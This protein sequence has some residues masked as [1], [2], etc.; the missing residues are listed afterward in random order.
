MGIDC[1]L[2][3]HR[4]RGGI[5]CKVPGPNEY[6]YQIAARPKT[7]LCVNASGGHGCGNRDVVRSA[8]RAKRRLGRGITNRWTGATGSEFR[9][10]RDPAKLLASAVARSTQPFGAVT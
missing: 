5:S 3:L 2:D 8:A 9:I 6:R 7:T 4:R 1:F 10:K